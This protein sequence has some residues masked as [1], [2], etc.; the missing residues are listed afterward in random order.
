MADDLGLRISVCHFPPGTSK[1]NKIEH[2]MFCHITKNW[3]GK[4]LYSRAIVVNLIGHT[5]TEAGLRI[6]AELD[7][8]SYRTGIKV[9]DQE[10]AA[11]RLERAS[12]HGEWNY[13]IAPRE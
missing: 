4:P 2:R 3:R 8:N 13:T 9:S 1:W 10:L 12:F 11:V 5:T 7:T 6:Q